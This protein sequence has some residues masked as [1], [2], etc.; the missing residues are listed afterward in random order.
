MDIQLKKG[1]LDVCVLAS[2]KG[3]DSYG[4]QMLKDIKPHIEMSESTLYPILRRLE[5]SGMLETYTRECDGRLRRYYR[6]TASGKERMKDF[7]SD[8]NELVGVYEFVKG[9]NN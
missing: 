8:W 4:Y 3:G 6:I 2:L 9:E 7:C 5:Q 1:V